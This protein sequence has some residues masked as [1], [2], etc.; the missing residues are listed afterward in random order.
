MAFCKNIIEGGS[1]RGL[2]G[3]VHDQSDQRGQAIN[4]RDYLPQDDV[5][6]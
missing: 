6:P 4:L 5:S 1:S 2:T 3:R